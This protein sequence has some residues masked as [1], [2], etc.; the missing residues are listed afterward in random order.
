[1]TFVLVLVLVELE[2]L[3]E[4]IILEKCNAVVDELSADLRRKV[5]PR[6]APHNMRMGLSSR[7]SPHPRSIYPF[8][9]LK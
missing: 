7:D 2:R 5:W 1:M 3:L 9:K 4:S 8:N 6:A